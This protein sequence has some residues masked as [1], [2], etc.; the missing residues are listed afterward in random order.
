LPEA[1]KELFI[2][3]IHKKSDKTDSNN[4]RSI[5]LSRLTPYVEEI[6]GDQQCGFQHNKSTTDHT[7][8]ICQILEK[9]WEHS[10]AVHQLFIDFQKAYNSVSREIV[11]NILND[12]G[13]L[14]KLIR[15]IK[16]CLNEMYSRVQ[17]GED[18]S[19]M[20]PIRNGLK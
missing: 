6:I 8:C 13:I 12:F 4:Y 16:M 15:L 1:W 20:F 5:S 17:V 2:L 18:F 3:P 7:Y 9:K 19:D 10:G 11:H 14:M